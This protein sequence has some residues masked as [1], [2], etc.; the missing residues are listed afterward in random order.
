[1]ANITTLYR[2]TAIGPATAYANVVNDSVRY[3]DGLRQLPVFGQ[4]ISPELIAIP[5]S[6]PIVE[7]RQSVVNIGGYTAVTAM[8]MHWTCFDDGGGDG[9]TI[10]SM[11]ANA[12]LIPQSV[13]CT[14]GQAAE[15]V[16]RALFLAVPTVGTTAKSP[17]TATVIHTLGPTTFNGSALAG[18]E[19]QELDFGLTI[20]TDAG[21]SG[22]TTPT[23][24][25]ITANAPVITITTTD[26][27]IVKD[28]ID[29]DTISSNACV[30]KFAEVVA[31]SA[32]YQYTMPKA[33]VVGRMNGGNPSTGTLTITGVK[34]GSAILT[35]AAY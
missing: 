24:V 33:H 11:L 14:K 3:S 25:V 5:V 22:S 23:N 4:I 31:G 9:S 28:H 29:G 20:W 8:G 18:I 19:S 6:E 35:G 27:S 30:L 7:W 13:R 16:L 10:I 12:K 17:T 32:N 26:L 21:Q 1:M 15:M 2:L 34:G